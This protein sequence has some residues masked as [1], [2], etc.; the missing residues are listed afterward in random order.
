[1]LWSDGQCFFLIIAS[2]LIVLQ[3]IWI[4]AMFQ[5][6]KRRRLGEPLSSTAFQRELKRIFS[7]ANGFS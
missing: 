5:R 6:N 2:F 1:M 3:I 7:K 4:G